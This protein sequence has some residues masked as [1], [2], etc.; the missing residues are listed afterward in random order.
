MGRPGFPDWM[1]KGVPYKRKRNIR[2]SIHR[3]FFKD[4]CSR[5]FISAMSAP[6]TARME[7]L[8]LL[9]FPQI[10]ALCA[11]KDAPCPLLHCTMPARSESICFS[12][13]QLICSICPICAIFV[14]K[15]HFELGF[16]ELVNKCHDR[17]LLS[18]HN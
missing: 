6:T 5:L 10:V 11:D 15:E 8:D 14:S 18:R 7:L 12:V 9:G 2:W 16:P 3:V 1:V 4:A 17:R 13:F